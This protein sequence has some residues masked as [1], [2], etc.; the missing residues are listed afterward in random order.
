MGKSNMTTYVSLTT[1]HI[2]KKIQA[3]E[4]YKSQLYKKP[5][6]IDVMLSLAQVRG[7]EINKDYAEAFE[8]VRSII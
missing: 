4:C 7:S 8:T 5:D 3:I 2:E 6:L 1:E